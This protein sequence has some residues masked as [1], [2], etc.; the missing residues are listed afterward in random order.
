MSSVQSRREMQ[1]FQV[2][3][4]TSDSTLMLEPAQQQATLSLI[5]ESHAVHRSTHPAWEQAS[6]TPFKRADEPWHF[7]SHATP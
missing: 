6:L 5:P 3:A 2:F 1:S 7:P 4:L